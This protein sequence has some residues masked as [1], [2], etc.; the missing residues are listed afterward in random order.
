MWK[1]RPSAQRGHLDRSAGAS[2]NPP[3]EP[4]PDQKWQ[5][6]NQRDNDEM[7]VWRRAV[8]TDAWRNPEEQHGH[9]SQVNGQGS[10]PDGFASSGKNALVAIAP[11]AECGHRNDGCGDQKRCEGGSA[12]EGDDQDRIADVYR[13]QDD[14]PKPVEVGTSD[15]CPLIAHFREG[16]AC[17]VTSDPVRAHRPRGYTLLSSLASTFHFRGQSSSAFSSAISRSCFLRSS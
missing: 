15:G 14:K 17:L 6:G 16:S 8:P 3:D 4:G 9:P 2:S 5:Y 11:K 13:R 1:A 12:C 7:P 10:P